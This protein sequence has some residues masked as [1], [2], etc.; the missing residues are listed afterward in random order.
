MIFAWSSIL[1][2]ILFAL[3]LGLIGFLALHAYRDGGSYASLKAF[4]KSRAKLSRL[5]ESLDHYEIPF[6]GRLANSFVDDE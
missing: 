4:G 1:S 3:D 5:V 6:F 2:W